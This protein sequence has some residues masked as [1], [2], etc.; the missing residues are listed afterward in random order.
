[1]EKKEIQKKFIE[2][3]AIHEKIQQMQQQIQTA[4]QQ[5]SDLTAP[6]HHQP[7]YERGSD[8]QGKPVTVRWVA[9]KLPKPTCADHQQR[10]IE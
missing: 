6:Q 2:Y 4:E 10:E 8:Q 7:R 5:H 9:I 1:M 3:Q